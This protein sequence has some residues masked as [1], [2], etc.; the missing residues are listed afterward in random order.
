[1]GLFGNLFSAGSQKDE[2]KATAANVKV[3]D[4]VCGMKVDP[5]TAPAIS[6]YMGKTY[7]FCAPGCKKTFDTNPGKYA[8]GSG[9]GMTEHS[10]HMM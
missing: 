3:I 8:E 10:G 7:Y 5:K 4:P 1:M 6:E 2:H 9:H